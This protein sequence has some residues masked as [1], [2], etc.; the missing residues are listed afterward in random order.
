MDYGFEHMNA[1]RIMGRHFT[2][3]PASGKIMEKC[4]MKLEGVLRQ[5]QLKLGEFVDVAY[6]GILRSEWVGKWGLQ[7][8]NNHRISKYPYRENLWQF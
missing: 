4:G 2:G 6:Y 5:D 1:N 7:F 3:N 8:L